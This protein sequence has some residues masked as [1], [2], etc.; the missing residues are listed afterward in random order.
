[1]GI[2]IPVISDKQ[3]FWDDKLRY[4]WHC[5]GRVKGAI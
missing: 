5:F 2:G 4:I 3:D 1:M